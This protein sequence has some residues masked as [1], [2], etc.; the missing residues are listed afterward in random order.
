MTYL[1]QLWMKFGAVILWSFSF[2]IWQICF[3]NYFIDYKMFTFFFLK[4]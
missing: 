3:P 2:N 1:Q 4:D